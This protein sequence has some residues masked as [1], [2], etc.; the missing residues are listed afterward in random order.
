MVYP[1]ASVAGPLVVALTRTPPATALHV[2]VKVTVS[3]SPGG[4]VTVCGLLPSTRQFS[5]TPPR[6]TACSPVDN[7]SSVIAAFT[8]TGPRST[9]STVRVYPSGS[10]GQ[11]LVDW[12]MLRLPVVATQ[13]ITKEAVVV[14]PA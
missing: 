8:P 10:A 11:P 14:S 5:A 6:L 12:D 3:D 1:S 7:P 2:T 13:V 4:T 9:P